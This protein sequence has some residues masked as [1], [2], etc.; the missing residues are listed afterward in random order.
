MS[1]DMEEICWG[2]IVLSFEWEMVGGSFAW[3]MTVSEG[4]QDIYVQA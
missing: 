4:I 2:G 3:D 1:D